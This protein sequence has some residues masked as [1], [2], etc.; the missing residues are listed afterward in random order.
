MNDNDDDD[1][2]RGA[3]IVAALRHDPGAL[4]GAPERRVE[5]LTP[6]ILGIARHILTLGAGALVTYGYIEGG[7]AETLIGAGVGI[8]GVIWSVIEKRMRS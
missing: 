3:A 1:E 4:W 6:A 7:D 5:M 2:A 8:V